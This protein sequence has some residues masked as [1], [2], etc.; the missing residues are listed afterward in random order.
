[1]RDNPL[2]QL[3]D[4]V[5]SREDA[6]TALEGRLDELDSDPAQERTGVRADVVTYLDDTATLLD[7][8]G[9]AVEEGRQD[10]SEV[11]DAAHGYLGNRD[12]LVSDEQGVL[13]VLDD[14]Y[15]CRSLLRHATDAGAD[16]PVRVLDLACEATVRELLGGPVVATLDV[17]A[18][19]TVRDLGWP[20]A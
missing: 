17:A 10:W 2:R 15:L 6:W 8:L 20:T 18:A 1:M 4:A 16:S 11:L 3:V 5:E 19:Q 7:T 13:G 14:A 12:D 9:R